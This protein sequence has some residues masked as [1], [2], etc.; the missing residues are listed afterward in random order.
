MRRSF[1]KKLKN[2]ISYTPFAEDLIASYYAAFDEHTPS[3]VKATLLGALAYFIL[4][5]DSAPDFL[6]MIGFTDDAAVL[7]IA[8]QSLSSHITPAHE[9]AARTALEHLRSGDVS[10][11]DE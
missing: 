5:L 9:R 7:L 3:R 1:W 2:T 4:P 11:P 6:P 8:V 10:A